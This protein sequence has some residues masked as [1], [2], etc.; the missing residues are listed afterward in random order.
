MPERQIACSVRSKARRLRSGK[1]RRVHGGS[2]KPHA[3]QFAARRRDLVNIDADITFDFGIFSACE[4][5]NL[6]TCSTSK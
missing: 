6:Q 1:S 4:R 3:R 5:L 2:A